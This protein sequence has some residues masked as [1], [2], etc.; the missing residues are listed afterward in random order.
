VLEL[1][2]VRRSADPVAFYSARHEDTTIGVTS[3]A[4][5]DVLARRIRP[6]NADARWPETI[7]DVF[8]DSIDTV[9]GIPGSGDEAG[10]GVSDLWVRP[11]LVG[12]GGVNWY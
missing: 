7:T 10:L 6:K 3:E 4:F 12:L 9:S 2:H 8:V 5:A 1:C 11:R